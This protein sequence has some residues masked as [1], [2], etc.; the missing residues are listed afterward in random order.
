MYPVTC[1]SSASERQTLARPD[2]KKPHYLSNKSSDRPKKLWTTDDDDN[3]TILQQQEKKTHNPSP[4]IL[5]PFIV[6]NIAVSHTMNPSNLPPLRIQL[7][8]QQL[9]FPFPFSQPLP[10][11]SGTLSTPTDPKSFAPSA[12]HR[13]VETAKPAQ[14]YNTRTKP[15]YRPRR[16][17]EFPRL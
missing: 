16:S 11:L 15:P 2:L 7:P 17:V 8:Q 5:T 12:P 14:R 10:P 1:S 9:S 13:T 4:S 6:S 3:E